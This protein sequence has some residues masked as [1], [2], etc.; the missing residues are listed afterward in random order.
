MKWDP[1]VR[2]GGA[3]I[4]GYIIE[5]KPEDGDNFV[6]CGKTKGNTCKG[7]VRGLQE[8]KKYEFRVKAINKAGP[9]EPSDST[10]PHLARPKFRKPKIDRECMKK[11]VIKVGQQHLLDVKVTGDPKP[12]NTWT[13]QGTVS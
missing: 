2:D 10:L 12:T 7:P 9:G 5:M 8:G 1:P 6:E 11:V 13:I 3:P 4:E